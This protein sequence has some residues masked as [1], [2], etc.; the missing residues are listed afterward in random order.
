MDLWLYFGCPVGAGTIGR[1]VESGPFVGRDRQLAVLLAAFERAREGDGSVALV[2]GEPGIG[3]TRL[4]RELEAAA[5]DGGAAV[6]WGRA[7]DVDGARPYWPWTQVLDALRRAAEEEPLLSAIGGPAGL[8]G[9][10]GDSAAVVARI[11]PFLAGPLTSTA[12]PPG[13]AESGRFE[14]F[15]AIE[16][17]LDET[18]RIC[19]L[20]IVIDDLQWADP[21]SRR[22]LE[23]VASSIADDRILLVAT[24]RASGLHAIGDTFAAL[25]RTEGFL[26]V[27]LSGLDTAGLAG[28][29]TSATA[30]IPSADLVQAWHDRTGGNPFFVREL[31]AAVGEDD[32]TTELLSRLPRS[33]AAAIDRRLDDLEPED[34]DIL[35][36]LALLDRGVGEGLLAHLAGGEPLAAVEVAARAVAAGLLDSSG[37]P[38]EYRFTHD[39]VREALTGVPARRRA[40]LHGELADALESANEGGVEAIH[41]SELA[42]HFVAAA[43]LDRSNAP[44]AVRYSELAG[45]EAEAV[46]AWSEAIERYED[47]LSLV[48]YLDD[49]PARQATLLLSL[50]RAQYDNNEW[51]PAEHSL[52]RAVELNRDLEDWTRFAE[53]V[54]QRQHLFLRD[55]DSRDLVRQ[56]LA[57]DDGSDPVRTAHLLLRQCR[58]WF[59]DEAATAAA[60]AEQLADA[61]GVTEVK[62]EVVFWRALRTYVDHGLDAALPLLEETHERIATA[63]DARRFYTVANATARFLIEAGRLDEAAPWLDELRGLVVARRDASGLAAATLRAN[64]DLVRFLHGDLMIQGRG[65]ETTPYWQLQ[66]HDATRAEVKGDFGRALALAAASDDL[67]LTQ[68]ANAWY[69]TRAR[70]AW[71]AHGPAAARAEFEQCIEALG[72]GGHPFLRP[73]A[74]AYATLDDAIFVLADDALLEEALTQLE[75]LR[76]SRIVTL[77]VAGGLDQL[78]GGL[79]LHLD[80]VDDAEH[81]YRTG[82]DWAAGEGCPIELGRNLAGLAEVA[83]RR[84]QRAAALRRLKRAIGALE[85]C[86][87]HLW[88][89]KARSRLEELRAAPRRGRASFP[90]GLS[91]TEVEVLRLL[92]EGLRYADI[93]EARTIALATVKR[94]VAS[95]L[96]K[97]STR[98]RQQASNWA[99]EHGLLE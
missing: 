4:V 76:N 3:K 87:A 33:V 50:G 20:V 10:L 22:L 18:A 2:T 30:R 88:S 61:H 17:L 70:I 35:R 71:R 44:R 74:H 89:E 81:W 28:W 69:G 6:L 32:S 48:A 42:E 66:L 80:R 91:P 57:H 21:S 53:A 82:A 95:I 40:E 31:L 59:D 86:G 36:Y 90:A 51:R 7:P 58:E 75:E 15:V 93:A 64:D 85:G 65:P 52:T 1:M 13:D 56:A 79:A 12:Q 27:E 54:L 72:R 68:R 43:A 16:R 8:L 98:N 34:R 45:R 83:E 24:C 19:P 92:A 25:S 5:R 67:P 78:R 11:A 97:T 99:A 9:F 60:Q 49:G 14:L 46:W 84:G 23:L 73:E 39:L 94:H 55:E 26:S 38:P 96:R 29:L 37:S 77:M 41:A 62:A 63:G 47:A